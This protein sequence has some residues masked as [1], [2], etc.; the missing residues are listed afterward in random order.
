MQTCTS[1]YMAAVTVRHS[2]LQSSTIVI[3]H[4]VVSSSIVVSHCV[5]SGSEGMHKGSLKPVLHEECGRQAC[6]MQAQD[7]SKC[8]RHTAGIGMPTGKAKT[9]VHHDSNSPA[10]GINLQ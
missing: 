5:V 10:E 1:A 6:Q 2:Q 7:H 9:Q 8:D 4:C 3:S